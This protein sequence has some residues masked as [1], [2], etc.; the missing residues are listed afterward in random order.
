MDNYYR[1]MDRLQEAIEI[2]AYVNPIAKR[3][4][5]DDDIKKS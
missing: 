1:R 4:K 5:L 2:L 3:N